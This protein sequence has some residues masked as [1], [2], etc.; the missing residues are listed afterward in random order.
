MNNAWI[1]FETNNAIINTFGRA[2]ANDLDSS[3]LLADKRLVLI[4][5][6]R[7]WKSDSYL[8]SSTASYN[9]RSSV[10]FVSRLD[11][12]TTYPSITRR[13]LTVIYVKPQWESIPVATA[14]PRSRVYL[15]SIP[16]QLLINTAVCP[17]LKYETAC[18][19]SPRLLAILSE[20]L[21]S[22]STVQFDGP[23]EKR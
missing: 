19:L 13:R 10:C 11:T 2:S 14:F 21:S 12:N 15:R 18:L 3:L 17:H 22:T 16:Y 5:S 8:S 1:N 23:R 20:N 9:V 7:R 6:Y 4:P